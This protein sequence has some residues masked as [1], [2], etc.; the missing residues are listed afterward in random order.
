MGAMLKYK[1]RAACG[2]I[3][4]FPSTRISLSIFATKTYK[5]DSIITQIHS[6]AK[7]SD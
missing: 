3:S 5:M 7:V 2:K 6:L 4:D 1:N